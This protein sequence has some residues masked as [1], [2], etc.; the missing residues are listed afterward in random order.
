MPRNWFVP[1]LVTTLITPPV[2]PPNSALNPDVLIDISWMN[3]NGRLLLTFSTPVRKL[4]VSSPS[5][6]NEFSEPLAPS[7]W[8]CPLR[9]SG[10]AAGESL[11]RLPMF[12][13]LGRFSIVAAVTLVW[14]VVWAVS[15]RAAS[16]STVTCSAT[17][18]TLNV[19]SI[20]VVLPMATVD[21]LGQARAE[22]LQRRRQP[23]DPRRA[24][25]RRCT[26]RCRR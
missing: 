21:V 13:P 26:G 9:G 25:R 8:Y 3:S 16:A 7:I 12:V 15:M 4:P 14:M 17:P 19:K 22:A 1:L 23:I 11:R 6:M 24:P 18:P 2:A 20:V 10:R 5:I